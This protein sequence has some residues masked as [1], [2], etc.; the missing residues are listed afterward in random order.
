[1]IEIRQSISKK[2]RSENSFT[3]SGKQQIKQI[4]KIESQEAVRSQTLNLKKGGKNEKR[5][6]EFYTY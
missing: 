2:S 1:M 4:I 6:E 3:D 5:T